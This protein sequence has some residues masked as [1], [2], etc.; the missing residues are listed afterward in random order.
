MANNVGGN[1]LI[2][3]TASTSAI[4]DPRNLIITGVHWAKPTGAGECII[5][6]G[7]GR[8]LYHLSTSAANI[9]VESNCVAYAQDGIIMHTLGSGTAYVYIK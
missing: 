8:T 7:G 1:P 2:L 9:D 3:D 6:D 4:V 5:K